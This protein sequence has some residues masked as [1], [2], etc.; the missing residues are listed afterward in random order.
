MTATRLLGNRNFSAHYL[1]EP[2]LDIWSNV[3]Q[4][5]TMQHMTVSIREAVRMC[6][7]VWSV[8]GRGG[9]DLNLNIALSVPFL[10][11]S[12]TPQYQ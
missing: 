2:P 4:H 5:G 3:N 9:L 7:C 6:V 10:A 11:D 12:R 8:G 1:L